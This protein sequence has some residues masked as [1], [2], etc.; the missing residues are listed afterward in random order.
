M[1]AAVRSTLVRSPTNSASRASSFPRIR[2]S[3]PHAGLLATGVRVNDVR[4]I[5]RCTEEI[6]SEAEEEAFAASERLAR[7]TL[8][9]QGAHPATIAFRREYDARYRGQ[10]FELTIAYDRSRNVVERRFHEAHRTRYG[11]DAPGEIVEVVNARLTAHGSVTPV[12]QQA[13]RDSWRTKP[14]PSSV[15]RGDEQKRALW[16]DDAFIDVSV[17]ER[18]GLAPAARVDGPA[19]VEAYD[20][21]VYIARDWELAVDG[22]LLVLQRMAKAA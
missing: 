14:A 21:T 1:E 2:D 9:E 13:Q 7:A 17:F 5:L 16:L 10:S 6:D 15:K 19:I 12:T 8:F 3:S 20:S 11:Y 22:D 18:E 4:S